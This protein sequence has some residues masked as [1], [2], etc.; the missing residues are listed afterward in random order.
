MQLF[1]TCSYLS[2]EECIVAAWFFGLIHIF[3]CQKRILSLDAD[4]LTVVLAWYHAGALMLWVIHMF[5][6]VMMRITI[7]A[8]FSAHIQYS[9]LPSENNNL[10]LTSWSLDACSS[11]PFFQQHHNSF[12]SFRALSVTIKRFFC[13][14]MGFPTLSLLYFTWVH[15][16]L[17]QKIYFFSTDLS[18]FVW[19]ENASHG[20]CW[21]GLDN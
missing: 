3:Y 1:F 11:D 13:K 18:L 6:F 8:H 4:F 15:W 10:S 9:L 19:Y 20:N 16:R 12:W 14:S 5:M 17:N 2:D 21:F 7:A